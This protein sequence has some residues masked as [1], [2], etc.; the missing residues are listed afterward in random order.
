MHLKLEDRRWNW[1]DEGV[2]AYAL[3]LMR[4]FW[5]WLLLHIWAQGLVGGQSDILSPPVV[6]GLLAGGTAAAQAGVH[7]VRRRRPAVVLV[8]L[9]GLA[10]IAGAIYVRF[11]AAIA[12]PWQPAWL[13]GVAGHPGLALVALAAGAWL[14]WWGILAGREPPFY[15]TYRNNFL[16]GMAAL[17]VAVG[18][19][20]ATR[21]VPMRGVLLTGLLFFATGLAAMAVAG[22]Q[23][24]RR[25]ERGKGEV[26]LAVTR[27]WLGTVAAVI[28]ALI[29]LGLLLAQ[30]FAPDAV[31]RLIG[32]LNSALDLAANILVLILMAFSYVFFG[33]LGLIARLFPGGPVRLALPPMQ[34]PDLSQQLKDMGQGQPVPVAPG[35]YLALRIAGAFLLVLALAA[36]F[37]LAFRRFRAIGREEV[38]ETRE[39]IL[40]SDLIKQQLAD[41]LRRRRRPA[42]VPPPFV[43]VT[44]GDAAGQIRLTYQNLLAWAADQGLARPPGATPDEY[45]RLLTERLG[46]AAEP[47]RALNELY[48][49]A[50]YGKGTVTLQDAEKATASWGEIGRAYRAD[51]GE[52]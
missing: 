34:I 5:V 28:G 13:N 44:G 45:A 14:W 50:R 22:V 17:A 21:V 7:A 30:L 26:S 12:P 10:A 33:L 20:Q 24:T 23:D 2:L 37:A 1:I 49:S 31:T 38:S 36:L 51:Q 9:A 42:P 25:F 15:D 11:G 35:V 39:S 16:L 41:L 46:L 6:F 47:L 29:V 43:S 4:A 48:L 40:T 27:Y 32:L 18:V 8:V 3:A 19:T 52:S